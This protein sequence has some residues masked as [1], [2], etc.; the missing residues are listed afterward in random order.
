MCIRDSLYGA[1]T[2]EL[3][4]N[5]WLTYIDARSRFTWVETSDARSVSDSLAQISSYFWY[6]GGEPCQFDFDEYERWRQ[7]G[8][9]ADPAD[10]KTDPR[11][12]IPYYSS[13]LD[14]LKTVVAMGRR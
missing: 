12:E 13:P 2:I 14:R 1:K 4:I 9:E 3:A 10:L 5:A 6:R 7:W 8:K 11:Y